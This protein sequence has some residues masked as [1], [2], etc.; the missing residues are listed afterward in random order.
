MSGRRRDD[1][2]GHGDVLMDPVIKVWFDWQDARLP[3]P[4]CENWLIA[5]AIE[6]A[7]GPLPSPIT[8][9]VEMPLGRRQW[10]EI[11][12][13]AIQKIASAFADGQTEEG[14]MP[15]KKGSSQKTISKNIRTEIRHGK[16][17]DQAVA[18]AMRVAGKPKPRGASRKK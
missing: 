15:L 2:V 10:Q 7:L 6:A 13:Q 14:K 12:L 17:R 11:N 3:T 18:I 16:P 5:R 9:E 1:V 4:M 8:E